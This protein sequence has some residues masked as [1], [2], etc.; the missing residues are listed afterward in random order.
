MVLFEMCM[1]LANPEQAD[2]EALR[3]MMQQQ[4]QYDEGDDDN[5]E[6]RDA[7]YIAELA[8]MQMGGDQG[9]MTQ[10]EIEDQRMAA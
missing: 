1:N 6:E 9:P 3:Q 10:Q 8:H 4:Q 7:N 2:P 5:E